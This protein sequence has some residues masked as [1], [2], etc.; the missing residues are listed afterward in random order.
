MCS[1][2]IFIFVDSR[3][4]A[5]TL[6]GSLS[7]STSVHSRKSRSSLSDRHSPSHTES[8]IRFHNSDDVYDP[9]WI[10]Q[11]SLKT[12]RAIGIS[13][14]LV[15]G[16]LYGATFLPI[17]LAVENGSL[18]S[19]LDATFSHFT[20]IL[21]SHLFYFLIYSVYRQVFCISVIVDS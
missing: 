15:S 19:H 4:K 13:L 7:A 2:L 1:L 21:I 3:G 9:D 17:T 16:A 18:D 20:G 11:L 14:C 12:R 8:L 6:S 10:D 5:V